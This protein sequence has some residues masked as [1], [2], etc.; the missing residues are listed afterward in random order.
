MVR[1]EERRTSDEKNKMEQVLVTYKGDIRSLGKDG[2]IR[3]AGLAAG[4]EYLIDL[5]FNMSNEKDK[6]GN[7]KASRHILLA[8]APVKKN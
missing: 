1:I 2:T 4:Q 8:F 7:V 5:D 6:N 3:G